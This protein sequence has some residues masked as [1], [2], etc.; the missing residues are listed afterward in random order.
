MSRFFVFTRTKNV[1]K[2]DEEGKVILKKDE[3]GN[4]IPGQAEV[5]SRNFTDAINLDKII[6]VHMLEQD[7]VVVL[8]D[9]GHEVTEKVPVLKNKKQP[10]TPQNIVEEKQRSY[11]QSEISVKGEDVTRLYAELVKS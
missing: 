10:P 7:H 1:A 3:E 9:D 2:K 4:D 8:L 11:M 5:E 6:R